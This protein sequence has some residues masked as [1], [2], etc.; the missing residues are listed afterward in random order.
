[1]TNETIT[2]VPCKSERCCME[3]LLQ[4]TGCALLGSHRVLRTHC[5]DYMME[6][7]VIGTRLGFRRQ[8]AIKDCLMFYFGK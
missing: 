2:S 6:V 8:K 3:D 4:R 1:M 7:K 5:G